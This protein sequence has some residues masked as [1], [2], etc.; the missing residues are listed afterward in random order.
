MV[1]NEDLVVFCSW[2][3]AEFPPLPSSPPNFRILCVLLV[4]FF[5]FLFSFFS[6]L[7]GGERSRGPVVWWNAWIHLASWSWFN[8]RPLEE[9]IVIKKKDMAILNKI[10]RAEGC[11]GRVEI[12]F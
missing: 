1:E 10:E 8:Q 12:H 4:V 9:G 6:M 11:T 7:V 5:F 2:Q 3:L